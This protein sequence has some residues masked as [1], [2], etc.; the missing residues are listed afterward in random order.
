MGDV[1]SSLNDICKSQL[2]LPSLSIIA[3]FSATEG[4]P[5][6]CVYVFESVCVSS[7]CS[8][9]GPAL[10]QGINKRC[11]V[12]LKGTRQKVDTD[13]Q[14][15]RDSSENLLCACR[16]I[17]SLFGFRRVQTSCIVGHRLCCLGVPQVTCKKPAPH[18]PDRFVQQAPESSGRE[19]QVGM[20][21][22][23]R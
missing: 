8:C 9:Q 18:L 15:C 13:R 3:D 23:A 14:I 11:R 12:L 2:S 22:Q 19:R 20:D 5:F 7:L 17:D 21:K 10:F 4:G 1:V 16:C 6:V